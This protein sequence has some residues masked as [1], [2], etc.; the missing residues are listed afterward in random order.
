VG[1][2]TPPG[3]VSATNWWYF[4]SSG[5]TL[6]I[7][8][9][10][11]PYS[12]VNWKQYLD[13]AQ[14]LG[15]KIGLQVGAEIFYGGG[16]GAVALVRP[17]ASH[18]AL[19]F[20]TIYDE[21]YW[22][23]HW[24]RDPEPMASKANWLAGVAYFKAQLPGVKTFAVEPGVL[25]QIASTDLAMVSE[26]REYYANIDIVAI[27]QYDYP[28][29]ADQY[30]HQRDLLLGWSMLTQRLLTYGVVQGFDACGGTCAPP[31]GVLEDILRGVRDSGALGALWWI[32]PPDW[33]NHTDVGS[34]LWRDMVQA[35]KALGY[36]P[37]PRTR[38]FIPLMV[39]S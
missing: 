11:S 26:I 39:K 36:Q 28:A 1:F 24:F 8:N 32:P 35:S 18:P 22:N 34:Q 27:D 4:V 10:Y 30:T 31:E 13:E 21:P 7:A 14:S 9:Y 38:I 25:Y 3:G 29:V 2:Y 15:M 20:V 6:N 37:A 17:V 19:A 33:A 5:Q 16:E 23:L 12:W